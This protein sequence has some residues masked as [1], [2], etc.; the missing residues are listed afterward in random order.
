MTTP[1]VSALAEADRVAGCGGKAAGLARIL[2]LGLPVPAGF[3]ATAAALEAFLD[4]NGLRCR[5]DE[6]AGLLASGDVRAVSAAAARLRERVLAGVLP[7]PVRAALDGRV[8]ALKS[9]LIVRSSAL[10]EDGEAA[11]FAG[12]LDSVLDVEAG[13]TVAAALL[14]CWA[15]YWSERVLAYQRSRGLRLGGM[16]VVIQEQVRPAFAGVLF[17]ANPDRA[18][19]PADDLLIEY[20]PGHAEALVQ[21]R[22]DPGRVLVSRA[23]L[24]VR[25]LAAPALDRAED[26][27]DHAPPPAAFVDLARACLALEASCGVP[28]D[29]E[30]ALDGG[31][32]LW[33]VQ[34]RPITTANRGGALWSNANVNENYPGPVSPLLYSIARTSYYHYFRNLGLSFGL[35]EARVAAAEQPLRHLVG[36]HGARLYYH[37]SNIHAVLRA[38][39]FGERLAE[40]FSAF[41]GAEPPEPGRRRGAGWR[42]W[43]EAGRIVL[44]APRLFRNLPG[45]VAAFEQAVA[46][47]AGRTAPEK[48]AAAPRP[49]L[50]EALRG[51]LD[52]RFH[53]WTGAA[54]ADAAAMI[55]YGA[56]RHLLRREFPAADESA[57]HN[58]LLKGLADVVS[59]QPIAELWRLSRAVRADPDVAAGF[60]GPDSDA[61][62]A[63]LGQRPELSAFGAAL[64][65]Y[66]D[67][68]GFRRSG[69]LMLTVPSFRE[70]PG[71]LLDVLRAY[72]ALDGPSPDE[73]LRQQQEERAAETG[74]VLGVLRGRRLWRCLPW[75]TVATVV[76]RL[77]PWCQ[78]AIALRER[79]RMSQALLYARCRDIA[80]AIGGRLE[81]AGDLDRCDDVFL[82]TW[83]EIDEL[84][85]G[86]ALFPHHVRD[87][88]RLRRTAHAQEG[89][90]KP[91]DV[92]R[93]PAGE[94]L[95]AGGGAAAQAGAALDGTEA[96]TGVAACGGQVTGPAVVLAD[97]TECGRLA[98]GD[99]LVT[100]QTDPGWGPAFPLIGGLVLERGGMLSHG[101]ILAREYGIPSVVGVRDAARRIRPG[102]VVRIDGD[103]GV[104]HLVAR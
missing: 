10:G 97:V 42:A 57:L 45:R 12:Q 79:A 75:P 39:P 48:L 52:I 99:V 69:E 54:L 81:A 58:T 67:R 25:P 38:A 15:S 82:L 37:L 36:A 41:T 65:E 23:G 104:V 80:L 8:A 62:L 96:L 78:K 43:V 2:R 94:Y 61:L 85:S 74:R 83:Q 14:T 102:Q 27:K 46:D 59:G 4:H 49:A 5:A 34:A 50:L 66:L 86:C 7:A 63:A 98:P 16:G 95:P 26:G 101:A 84:L 92:F 40:Y 35:S 21:G 64:A 22:V 18:S 13:P 90:R 24:G 53:R 11:S 87:L 77:L 28:Q 68:W 56:L 20:C 31:G 73:R 9:P 29:V 100:R 76:K 33:L 71:P 89:A 3:V 19:G 60:A 30:W 32:R 51:F 91:P 93:L 1:F 6:L 70:Q 88:A 103:R 47:F 17:T 72:A 55:S 44:R